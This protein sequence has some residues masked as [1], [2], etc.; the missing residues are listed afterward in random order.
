MSFAEMLDNMVE[1]LLYSGVDSIFIERLKDVLDGIVPRQNKDLIELA[2]KYLYD[3]PWTQANQVWTLPGLTSSVWQMYLLHEITG[4][5]EQ[6]L[7]KG[8]LEELKR[9]FLKIMKM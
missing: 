5:Q 4:L 8:H 9:D 2:V 3:G 6:N 1:I 7:I